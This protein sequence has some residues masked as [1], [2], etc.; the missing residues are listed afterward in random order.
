MIRQECLT[1]R[2]L[3]GVGLA[4][5]PVLA[6]SESGELGAEMI[7]QECLTYWETERSR[8]GIPACLSGE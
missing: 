7:R 6:E 3:G 5:L 4:F 1:Y 8:T 2:G